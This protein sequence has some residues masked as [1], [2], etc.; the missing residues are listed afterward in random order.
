MSALDKMAA[1]ANARRYNADGQRGRNRSRRTHNDL[2]PEAVAPEE[3]IDGDQRF[4]LR[5]DD[6]WC[7]AKAGVEAWDL[8]V[9]ACEESHLA[10]RYFTKADDG[11]TKRWEGRVWCNPP[12]SDIEPWVM[13]A[14]TAAGCCDVIAMLLPASRTEQGWWQDLVEPLRDGRKNIRAGHRLTLIAH[15]LYTPPLTTHFLPGRTR[16]G[17]PG[18]RDGIGVG[19]PPFGCVLLVWRKA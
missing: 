18:N 11:L 7:R 8:D 1:E 5:E 2:F 6:L 12:F 19:S 16:F 4:T 10:D 17:H 9:A 14:W 15:S 13:K 3:I